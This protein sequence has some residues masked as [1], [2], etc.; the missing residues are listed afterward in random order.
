MSDVK[1]NGR[2]FRKLKNGEKIEKE[3]LAA[4]SDLLKLQEIE[5]QP[6]NV[7]E[8][9]PQEPAKV[10]EKKEEVVAENKIEE[11]LESVDANSKKEDDELLLT[12]ADILR[13]KLRVSEEKQRELER[14]IKEV[15]QL[16]NSEFGERSKPMSSVKSGLEGINRLR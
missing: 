13:N 1:L 8:P 6:E 16:G 14:K 5:N 15:E 9:I 11:K 4:I 7:V 2:L 12:E 10:E 3:E